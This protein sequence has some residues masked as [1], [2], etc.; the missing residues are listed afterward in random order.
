MR[1]TTFKLTI[2]WMPINSTI[3][4]QNNMNMLQIIRIYKPKYKPKD[5]NLNNQYYNTVPAKCRFK[6]SNTTSTI[7]VSLITH[8]VK[9]NK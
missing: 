2:L 4:L 7:L 6:I 3:I 9:K 5:K 1:A 8:R